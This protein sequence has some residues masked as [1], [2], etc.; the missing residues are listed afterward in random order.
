MLANWQDCH[1]PAW[2]ASR[3]HGVDAGSSL[4][5]SIC[6]TAAMTSPPGCGTGNKGGFA[7]LPKPGGPTAK[8]QTVKSPATCRAFAFQG[9]RIV[10][11]GGFG[12]PPGNVGQ[13][14]FDLV[15]QD[16]AQVTRLQALQRQI[17]G[18]ELAGNLVDALRAFG[19]LQAF[20]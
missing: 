7:A 15:D 1:P 6:N 10:A 3:S 19:M 4:A 11:S 13:G 12:D 14:L 18:L 2:G 17:D 9:A 20:A 8:R 16:Q 5:E